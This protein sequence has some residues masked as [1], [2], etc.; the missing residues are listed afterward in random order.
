MKILIVEDYP[1]L[2][3]LLGIF[4]DGSN[5]KHDKAM[6]VSNAIEKLKSE[7]FD[8]MLVDVFV[9]DGLSIPAIEFCQA[10]RPEVKIIL[11]SGW[12][13]GKEI[14]EKY[15]TDFFLDKPFVFETLEEIIKECDQRK[16][17]THH[18]S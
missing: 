4:L 2:I 8:A 13:G 16:D 11:M 18:Y 10:E 12:N 3:E 6:T 5:I 9:G 14:H 7:F 1:D 17:L 15:K